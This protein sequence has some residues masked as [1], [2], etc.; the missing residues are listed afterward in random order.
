MSKAYDEY[1]SEH[2]RRMREQYARGYTDGQHSMDAEH[3]AVAIRLQDLTFDG[4]S[5][6]NLRKIAYVIYPCA[7]EWTCESSEGLRDE[8]VRLM[9]GVHDEHLPNIWRTSGEPD[10]NG[11][12][13]EIEPRNTVESSKCRENHKSGCITDELRKWTGIDVWSCK[14]EEL[15]AIADRIDEQEAVLQATIKDAAKE[16]DRAR[17]EVVNL[18]DAYYKMQRRLE[19]ERDELQAKLDA[20]K[21]ILDG[22]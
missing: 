2:E 12:F 13:C 19:E 20:I 8:L 10:E 5:H 16:R 3:Y 6:E 18:R 15:N 1:L 11:E 7:T 14:W 9:G 4:D 17:M 21:G 22:R